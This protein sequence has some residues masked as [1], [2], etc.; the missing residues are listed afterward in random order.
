M[1]RIVRHDIAL[2]INL[3]IALDDALD[4]NMFT[5]VEAENKK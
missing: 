1:E 5:V 4:D 2:D 3:S